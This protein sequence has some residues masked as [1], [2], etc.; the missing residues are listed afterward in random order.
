[1]SLALQVAAKTDVGCVRSHNEDNF[2]Y[3][4]RRGVFVVCDGM[5]GQA[6][7]E[8]ASRLAVRTLLAYFRNGRQGAACGPS[9]DM[10]TETASKPLIE[11]ISRANLA[12]RRAAS[13][14]KQC[15]GMGST[16]VSVLIDDNFVSVAHVG[17]SRLY[18]VRDG[19]IRQ[20]TEDHSLVMQQ[21]SLGL[22]SPEQAQQSKL[23]NVITRAL[24]AEEAE[25]DIDDMIAA[26]NDILLLATD[27]LTKLV[28]KGQILSA[29]SSED[30]LDSSCSRLIQLA[31]EMGGDDNVTCLL[32]R[33][34]EEK[35]YQ[36]LARRLRFLGDWQWHGCI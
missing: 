35:W 24:G 21:V 14:D 10:R 3:D 23:Q 2:G 36:R 32:I 7:G 31:K 1:L 18:L 5:G 19:V 28:D 22:I 26:E 12:I 30:D 27:G 16:V 20:L 29:L 33:F 9:A 34:V 17:D 6:A 15:D 11:A 25:P 4:L 8:V 13:A